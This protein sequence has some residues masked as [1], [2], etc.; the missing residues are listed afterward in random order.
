[1]TSQLEHS[2]Q[3][4][5]LAE[6][7][8][9]KGWGGPPD[10]LLAVFFR[11]QKRKAFYLLQKVRLAIQESRSLLFKL[12]KCMNFFGYSALFPLTFQISDPL[13]PSFSF[14]AEACC[15][16]DLRGPGSSFPALAGRTGSSSA[17]AFYQLP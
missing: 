13:G 12:E 6:P 8:L 7:N 4:S 11:G 5:L 16:R 3:S 14:S 10:V 1:M 2:S 9:E 17:E 15:F